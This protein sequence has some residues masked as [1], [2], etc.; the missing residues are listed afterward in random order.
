MTAGNGTQVLTMD[1]IN[2]WWC[3]KLYTQGI[4]SQLKLLMVAISEDWPFSKKQLI[5]QNNFV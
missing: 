5:L 3:I 1:T 2:V 4:L